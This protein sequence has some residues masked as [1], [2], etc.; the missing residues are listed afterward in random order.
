MEL[1]NEKMI[2]CISVL[3]MVIGMAGC[4][5]MQMVGDTNLQDKAEVREVL[6]GFG[7]KLQSV[8]LLSPDAAQEIQENY[9]GYVSPDLMQQWIADVSKAP[10]RLV[11]SPWPERIEITSINQEGADTY[12]VE[13]NVIE[14]TSAEAAAGGAAA[15]TPVRITVQRLQGEWRITAFGQQ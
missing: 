3:G 13:G 12:I 1:E 10:G 9:A 11:S 15:S 2:R 4:R 8:S 14:V 5:V 7:R 6:E